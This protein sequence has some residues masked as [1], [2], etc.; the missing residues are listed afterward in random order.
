M[1]ITGGEAKGRTFHFP[2]KSSSRP[3]SDFLREAVFNILGFPENQ[4]FLDL[5]AG[6]GSVGLEALSRRAKNVVFVEKSKP[7][8]SIIRQNIALCGFSEK[9]LIIAND[10]Q[11][12]LRDLC[13]KQRRF[14]ILFADPPYHQGLIE[15]T[16]RWLEKYPVLQ[17][18]GIIIL[19]HSRKEQPV[20]W[21]D[22]MHL[23]DQRKYGENILSFVRMAVHDTG[24]I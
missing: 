22:G 18:D 2:P 4:H 6:S 20:N 8:A 11:S 5:Y 24:E 23:A 13:N 1:R 3:T 17:K 9:S 12:A 14:D 21:P 16:L 15:E 7:L 10:V 19:Q